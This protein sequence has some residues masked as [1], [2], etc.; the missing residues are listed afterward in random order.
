MDESQRMPTVVNKWRVLA[1][2]GAERVEVEGEGVFDELVVDDWI[3]LEQMND[4]VW[5]LRVGDARVTITVAPGQQ[6][7]V[8]ICRAFY[9]P[10]MGASSVHE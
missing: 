8:D 1:Y 3:H 6:P 10:Q 9:A 2:H 4:D 5:W 7:T